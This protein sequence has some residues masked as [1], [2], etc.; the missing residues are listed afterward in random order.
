MEYFLK[1]L[2]EEN[3]KLFFPLK[4]ANLISVNSH[5]CKLLQELS[6]ITIVSQLKT[7]SILQLKKKKKEM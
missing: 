7:T 2:E 6:H 1:L 3:E 4:E 5:P